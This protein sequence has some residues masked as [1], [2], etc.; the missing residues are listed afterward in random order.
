MRSEIVL[1]IVQVWIQ[2]VSHADIKSSNVGLRLDLGV[3][4]VWQ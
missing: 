1:V 4:S 2:V 3:H